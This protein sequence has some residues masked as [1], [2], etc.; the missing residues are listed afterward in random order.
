MKSADKRQTARGFKMP[1]V[2]FIF[3]RVFRGALPAIRQES[4][5]NTGRSTRPLL[6]L[7]VSSLFASGFWPAGWQSD[8]RSLGRLGAQAFQDSEGILG[9]DNQK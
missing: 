1:I 9:A 8:V 6:E 7:P 5:L 3:P 2:F 4:L